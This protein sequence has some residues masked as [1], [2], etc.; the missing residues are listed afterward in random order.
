MGSLKDSG[1]KIMLKSKLKTQK[2]GYCRIVK[3][4]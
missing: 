4:S 2:G 3:K 1:K